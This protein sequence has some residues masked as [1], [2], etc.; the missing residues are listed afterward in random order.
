MADGERAGGGESET[1]RARHGDGK[2]ASWMGRLSP[3]FNIRDFWAADRGDS[4]GAEHSTA[5]HE[6]LFL[7]LTTGLGD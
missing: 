1:V 5:F 6:S 4:G 2:S 3:S 7:G